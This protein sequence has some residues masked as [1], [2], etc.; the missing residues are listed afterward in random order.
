[1]AQ[2]KPGDEPRSRWWTVAFVAG[3]IG[4]VAAIVF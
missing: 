2:A 4:L 1:V 3:I